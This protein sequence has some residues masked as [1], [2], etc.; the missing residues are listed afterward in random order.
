MVGLAQAVNDLERAGLICFDAKVPYRTDVQSNLRINLP[1]AGKRVQHLINIGVCKMVAAN[2][3]QIHIDGRQ[4]RHPPFVPD[5]RIGPAYEQLL[6]VGT[7]RAS[8]RVV[9]KHTTVVVPAPVAPLTVPECTLPQCTIRAAHVYIAYAAVARNSIWVSKKTARRRTERDPTAPAI[10]AGP[11]FLP[12]LAVCALDEYVFM[13]WPHRAK[14]RF[15][16]EHAAVVVAAPGMPLAIVIS[17]LP[18]RIVGAAN[19]HVA[20]T[21]VTRDRDRPAEETVGRR[22]ERD[23]ATPASLAGPP[24][25]VD[26]T[27]CSANEQMLM[28]R[29]H[30]TERRRRRK[31]TTI[32]VHGPGMPHTVPVCALPE[33]VVGT[34]RVDVGYTGVTTDRRR[35]TDETAT[36]VTHR[37]PC[38][39]AHTHVPLQWL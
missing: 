12:D 39:P 10:C 24:F 22:A 29:P 31:H 34:A 3:D 19:V 33:S 36:G 6:M 26:V 18:Q 32:I 9:S 25:L 28:I 14:R 2:C 4:L 15:R 23:P 7:A 11:P 1:R 30:R 17:K 5:L 38:T 8:G 35:S 13:V 21:T 37:N 27:V 20:H 16:G